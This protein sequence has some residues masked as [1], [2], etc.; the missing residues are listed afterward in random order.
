MLRLPDEI[1]ACLFDLDGVLTQTVKVH[2]TAWKQMFDEELHRREGE[3]FAVHAATTTTSTSTASP[4]TTAS[5]RSCSRAGYQLPRGR[6]PRDRQ[7]QE[8]ARAEADRRGRSRSTT[9]R[10]GSLGR[11]ARRPAHGGRLLE[12]QL[13]G[14]RGGRH[15]RPYLEARVDGKTIASEGLKGKPAP[16]TF[17]AGA[18]RSAPSRPRPRSSRTRWQAWRPGAPGTSA[19]SW[20]STA[21]TTRSGAGCSEHGA[22]IVVDDLEE[23]VP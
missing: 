15:R 6:D 16:D 1:S 13:P 3:A 18:R 23:L 19:S 17:L 22:D 20:A 7:P 8:R 12:R 21:A 4:A 14:A 10:C 5:A 9:G 11:R 2:P